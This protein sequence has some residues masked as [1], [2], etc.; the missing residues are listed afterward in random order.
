MPAHEGLAVDRLA[1]I[2]LDGTLIDASYEVTNPD[3]YAAIA[4]TQ[5]AGWQIG[6]SSDTPYEVLRTWR[7]RFGMNGPVVA[8]KGAVVEIGS[9]V[10]VDTGTIRA[11]S[12]AQTAVAAMFEDQGIRVWPGEPVEALR[13][14]LRVGEAGERVILLN[15]LSQASLRFFVRRVGASRELLS[16]NDATES[17]AAQARELYPAFDDLAEDVNPTHGLVIASRRSHTK[18]EGTRRLMA[19]LG[20]QRIVMV[21]N[22]MADYIG[23]DIAWHGAVG[24]AVPAFQATADYTA[25][26]QLTEGVTEILDVL[27]SWEADDN[28]AS[29]Y[30]QDYESPEG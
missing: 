30:E 27:R 2:D 22:S 26:R 3:I 28:S 16:D 11:F 13:T 20:L 25:R 21:G 9:R 14:G 17:L 29:P 12:E 18:R 24:D 5:E 6:L 4:A 19:A 1:L 23:S 10:E 7:E 15:T 8:E